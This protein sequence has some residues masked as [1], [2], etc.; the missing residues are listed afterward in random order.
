MNRISKTGAKR[1]RGSSR[2]TSILS[3]RS[4]VL[5]GV[6]GFD[7]SLEVITV[8]PSFHKTKG[9]PIIEASSRC[10]LP[11]LFNVI[12]CARVVRSVSFCFLGRFFDALSLN[13]SQSQKNHFFLNAKMIAL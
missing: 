3:E 10:K 1:T 7:E 9:F 12:N 5:I 8:P 6:T 2:G 4:R 13:F 11:A